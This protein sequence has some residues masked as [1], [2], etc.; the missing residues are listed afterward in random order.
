MIRTK[1]TYKVSGIYQIQSKYNGKK[2]VGSAIN[3][4]KRKLYHL[5]DL[6]RNKHY[7]ILLQRHI[8]KY[9]IDDLIFSVIEKCLKEELVKREQYWIDTLKPE[10]NLCKVAG[11]TLGIKYSEE[12]KKNLREA[13][14]KRFQKPEEHLKL[15]EAF[16]NK[17]P[18][19]IETRKKKS[20]ATKGENNPMYGK[21]QS[22]EVKKMNSIRHKG[23]H[24]GKNN[25]MYGKKHSKEVVEKA[26]IRSKKWS[27]ENP[28][29]AKERARR[30][31]EVR[32]EKYN[33]IHKCL[34]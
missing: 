23:L 8:N 17:P 3:L 32:L 12:A 14:Y 29:L 30:M 27:E 11:S 19:S 10:F 6:K 25:P 34:K 20:N 9:G 2:Y 16:K 28:E 21:H 22:E 4:G 26:R 18:D 15:I 33:K 24:A 31:R 5:E 13:S 1:M 7:N